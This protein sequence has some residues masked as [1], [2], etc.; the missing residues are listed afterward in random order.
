MSARRRLTVEAGTIADYHALAHWHY[1]GGRP[2]TVARVLRAIWRPP[3]RGGLLAGVLVV[4]M[5][6]LN[7]RWRR[8]VPGESKREA[9]RRLNCPRRGVRC[10]SRVI[11]D[12]RFR[13]LGVA[14]V[15]VRAYL[16]R[17][18]TPST[19]AVAAMGPYSGFFVRAGMRAVA[20]P[21]SRRDAALR[22]A[23]RRAGVRAWRLTDAA[24]VARVAVRSADLRGA[25]HRWWRASRATR[26][27]G[28]GAGRD[29]GARRRTPPLRRII[30]RAAQTVATQTMAFTAHKH[31]RGKQ[32]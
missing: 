14:T 13:G 30:E 27:A 16:R 32:R 6:T 12:P 1:R 31:S 24:A 11:V 20:L 26:G 18:L 28:G 8:P 19:E 4:S 17:P 7:G 3:G 5:P 9:A 10:I 22:A 23:L 29:R 25:L 2:A 15:L 21:P